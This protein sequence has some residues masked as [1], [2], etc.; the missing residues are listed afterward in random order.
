MEQYIAAIVAIIVAILLL[1]RFVSCL[2]RSIITLA[3]MAILAY[4]YFTYF[5]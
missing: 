2:M 4:L 5:V 3:L 1:K